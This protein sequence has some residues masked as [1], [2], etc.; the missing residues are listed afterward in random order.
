MHHP[1]I[2]WALFCSNFTSSK[3]LLPCAGSEWSRW[4]IGAR[5]QHTQHGQVAVMCGMYVHSAVMH[6]GSVGCVQ[7]RCAG[8][9]Q[10]R[11]IRTAGAQTTARSGGER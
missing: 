8:H 1:L 6:T 11:R 2:F 7:K 10:A 9:F 4:E 3:R 5:A